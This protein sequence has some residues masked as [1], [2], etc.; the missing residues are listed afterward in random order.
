[1]TK[2][3]ESFMTIEEARRISAPLYEAL[4]KPREKNVAELLAQACNDDYHSYH[5]NQDFLTRDQLADVFKAMGESV[6]DLAWE[7]VDIHVVGDMM[8]VR[9][10]ATGTPGPGAVTPCGA[11]HGEGP[12]HRLAT[13]SQ[14]L[15]L[16]PHHSSL[17]R[18]P[19]LRPGLE[20][21]PT[22]IIFWWGSSFARRG[23]GGR[24]LSMS[25]R[26]SRSCSARPKRTSNTA[27]V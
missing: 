8:I 18:R 20:S 6:P 25:A 1:M 12:L 23:E 14:R 4:N 7:V 3:D 21:N 10:E 27:R 17:P 22:E 11:D 5:T 13:A 26:I 15:G 24:N 2:S 9:G 16:H 19:V